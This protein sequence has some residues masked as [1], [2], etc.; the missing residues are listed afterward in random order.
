[1][2]KLCSCLTRG[3][4]PSLLLKPWW[5][6]VIKLSHRNCV[7]KILSASLYPTNLTSKNVKRTS[8]RPS[9][10]FDSVRGLWCPLAVIMEYFLHWHL[11]DVSLNPAFNMQ[12]TNWSDLAHLG[13]TFWSYL[14]PTH[15]YEL[16]S[17]SS[18][19][20]ATKLSLIKTIELLPASTVTG[21]QELTSPMMNYFCDNCKCIRIRE[22]KRRNNKCLLRESLKEVQ[23][24][25]Q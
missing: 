12:V 20:K 11:G 14:S 9:I 25:W 17:F 19:T 10:V 8:F 18:S 7:Q 4:A 6:L 21:L 1:M 24:L 5:E 16:A 2:S 22:E 3:V 15:G 23:R 13:L